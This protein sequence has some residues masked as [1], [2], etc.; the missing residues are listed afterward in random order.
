MDWS[1]LS[2]SGLGICTSGNSQRRA[3]YRMLDGPKSYLDTFENR[4][5]AGNVCIT[6]RQ[7][8]RNHCCRGKA[9]TITYSERVPAALVIQHAMRMRRI[10]LSTMACPTVPYFSTCSHNRQDFWKGGKKIE[11]KSYVVILATTFS[12]TFLILRS[13]ERDITVTVRRSP[14]KYP[15][16]LLDFNETLRLSTDFLKIL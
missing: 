6:W 16:F 8:S 14:C 5:K 13:I 12:L 1:G 3:L 7:R 4:K 11:Q 2:A 9:S 15:L 10:I